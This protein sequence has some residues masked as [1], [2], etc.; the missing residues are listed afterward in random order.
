MT[1]AATRTAALPPQAELARVVAAVC[2]DLDGR[3]SALLADERWAEVTETLERLSAPG[4]VARLAR[5]LGDEECARIAALLLARWLALGE[6][7]LPPAAAIRG[8]FED[9]SGAELTV[10]VDGLEEGWTATWHGPVEP[11]VADAARPSVRLVGHRSEPAH[12]TVR[13]FGRTPH[14]RTIL[15]AEID[16][17]EG[18][19]A[20][21]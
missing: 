9:P 10:V 6:V 19:D 1:G 2:A 5:T 15:A 11:V 8:P 21:D 12:V 14:G 20:S 4:A 7:R 3:W 13:V 16:V 18:R 17:P